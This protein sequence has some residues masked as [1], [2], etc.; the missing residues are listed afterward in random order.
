[1]NPFGDIFFAVSA[2]TAAPQS[3]LLP[4]SQFLEF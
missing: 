1:M 4:G 3:A 2:P